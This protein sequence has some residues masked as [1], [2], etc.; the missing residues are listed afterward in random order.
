[1]DVELGVGAAVRPVFEEVADGL[2][3]PPPVG[4][5]LLGEVCRESVA[6]WTSPRAAESVVRGVL[7]YENANLSGRENNHPGNRVSQRGGWRLRRVQET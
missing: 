2:V 3:G 6:S 5:V 4:Q 7:I 1:M